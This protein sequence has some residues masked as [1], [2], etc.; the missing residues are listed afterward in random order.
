MV[1]YRFKMTHG[2]S[3]KNFSLSTAD[4]FVSELMMIDV[5]T[6]KSLRIPPPIW[7]GS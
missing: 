3:K 1:T 5:S 7:R 6:Y 4:E 2:K